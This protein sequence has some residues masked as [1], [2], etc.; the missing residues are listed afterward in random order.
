VLP[1]TGSHQIATHKTPANMNQ[2]LQPSSVDALTQWYAED[3]RFYALCQKLVAEKK[4]G[5]KL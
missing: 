5:K 2:K 3:I 4:V 1:I